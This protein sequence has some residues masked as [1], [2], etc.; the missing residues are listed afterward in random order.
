MSTGV[1]HGPI[2]T[3]ERGRARTIF[4]PRFWGPFSLL[5]VL[6]AL[7]DRSLEY[8]PRRAHGT[9]KVREAVTLAVAL[10][11]PSQVNSRL[12]RWWGKEDHRAIADPC[13][14]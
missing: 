11:H 14:D 2:V 5:P 4:P 7:R 6:F 3:R 13:S 8:E 1:S 9:R 10:A 12:R